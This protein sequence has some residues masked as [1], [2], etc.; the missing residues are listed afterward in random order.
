MAPFYALAHSLVPI[1][2]AAGLG[3]LAFSGIELGYLNSILLL[4]ENGRAAQYQALHSS[5]FGIRGSIAPF[6]AI[7]LMHVLGIRTALW[8]CFAV[9]IVG[10]GLQLISVREHR[11]SAERRTAPTPRLTADRPTTRAE[12]SATKGIT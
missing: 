10:V 11:R 2:M 9:M 7:P 3:G 4:A 12:S 8:A 6:C 5:L 1:Y